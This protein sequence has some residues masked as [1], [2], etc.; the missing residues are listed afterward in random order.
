MRGYYAFNYRR[1]AHSVAKT[2]PAAIVEM[3]F[4][5]NPD[6]RTLLTQS[7]DLVAIGIA[8]GII[9]YLN[10][11]DEHVRAT[12]RAH[13]ERLVRG[14]QHEDWEPAHPFRSHRGERY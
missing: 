10:E 2:T 8:N 1:Y 11:R 5:T 4:L 14:V 9:R 13:V 7:P 12:C 3:G 6:D